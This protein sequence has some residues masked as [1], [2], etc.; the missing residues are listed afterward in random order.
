MTCYSSVEPSL[1]NRSLNTFL[2]SG[3]FLEFYF[4]PY[5]SSWLLRRNNSFYRSVNKLT[6]GLFRRIETSEKL[7]TLESFCQLWEEKFRAS[8]YIKK[9]MK[10]NAS[11]EFTKSKFWNNFN[12]GKGHNSWNQSFSPCNWARGTVVFLL[13]FWQ[14]YQYEALERRKSNQ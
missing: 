1:V 7:N 10:F 3:F 5:I 12:I 2:N 13:P 14:H 6:S 11:W 9:L 8:R 4:S